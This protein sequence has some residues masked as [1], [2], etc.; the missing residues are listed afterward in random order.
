MS[1]HIPASAASVADLPCPECGTAG[2]VLVDDVSTAELGR[3]YRQHGVEVA[4]YF[5]GIP[6]LSRFRCAACDLRFFV[7]ACAGDD[8]F[9]EQLQRF[10]WYYQDEKP[11]YEFARQAIGERRRVLEVGCGKGAFA[12]FLP[13]SAA[14]TGLE[15]N[16]EAV[17]KANEAG[18][19]VFREPIERHA[20]A[21]PG[22][23]D[24]V[25]SFQVLEH[26][27]SPRSFLDGCVAALAAGGLLVIAVPAEDSFLAVAANAPFNMP[28][29]HVLRWTDRAL[30]AMAAAR[31]LDVVEIWHEPVAPFHAEWHSRAL[32]H[33]YFVMHGVGTGRLIDTRLR[34]RALGRLL[35]NARLRDFLA[36]RVARRAPMLRHGHTV[37]LVARKRRAA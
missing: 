13:S 37:V 23:Y 17:R 21:H 6:T 9:Y 20:V 1:E 14:Y 34:Y 33:H 29:H 35:A 22:H 19:N 12:A 8:S 31:N 25:C 32:A 15:F 18:L 7:P 26:V 27:S 2:A 24:A 3:L 11:E 4:A 16:D 36:Q 10:D 28:P 5:D 30:A